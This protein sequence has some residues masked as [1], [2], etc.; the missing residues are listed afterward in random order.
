MWGWQGQLPGLPSLFPGSLRMPLPLSRAVITAVS[1]GEV[2]LRREDGSKTKIY[3][4]QLQKG[5]YSVH[6]A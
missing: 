1:T 5:K 3:V 2:W 6:K 4:S